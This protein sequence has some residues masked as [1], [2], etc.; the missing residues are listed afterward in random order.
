[1]GFEATEKGFVART[2]PPGGN[3]PL[4]TPVALI[5]KRKEEI[6]LFAEYS[7]GEPLTA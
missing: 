7:F 2:L 5:T 3:I 6:P 4:G 1:M